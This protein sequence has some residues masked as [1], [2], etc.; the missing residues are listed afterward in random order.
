MPPRKKIVPVKEAPAPIFEESPVVFFL[1][2]Q[3]EVLENISPA[4]HT[5]GYSDL[6]KPPTTMTYTEILKSMES[7]TF[8]NTELLKSILEKTVCD[9]YSQDT[10]C[11][12]CCHLFDWTASVVPIS[13]DAYK[14]TYACEGN[15]CSPECGLAWLYNDVYLSDTI[16]WNRHTL[17]RHL[18][19]SMYHARDLSPA[20]PRNLLRMFGGSLDI[21]QYRAYTYS[22]N[23]IVLSKLPPV[24]LVFPTMNIQGPLRDIKKYV[25]LS[26]ETIEKASQQLRLK[27]SKP[28]HA[29]LPTLD[30]CLKAH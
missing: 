16:R 7:T 8:M 18:Y 10:A 5:V 25:S 29:N 23:D 24:R 26:T 2:T 12:W 22:V 27:R 9:S 13:Y 20:P 1:R 14:N 4:G 3:D 30:M 19:G 15:F 11:F 21:S 28:V 17:L 6:T